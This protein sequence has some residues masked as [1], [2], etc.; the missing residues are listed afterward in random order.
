MS[1]SINKVVDF[2]NEEIKNK[3]QIFP[4]MP[5][6]E[7]LIP[8]PFI[9]CFV[10]ASGAGKT[11]SCINLVKRYVENNAFD[12]MV[13]FSPT[14]VPDERTSLTADD[15]YLKL[16]FTELYSEY[17]DDLLE[18]FMERQ[19]DDIKEFKDFLKDKKNW[20][21]Y[22]NDP[23]NPELEEKAFEIYE[24]RGVV[25]PE[26]ET[27][28]KRYPS[29][30]IILD[31]LGDDPSIKKTGKSK[32]NNFVS[33]IRHALCSFITNYQSLYMCPPT[34]RKQ[35][36]TWIIYKSQ[37]EKYLKSIYQECCSGDM[38]FDTFKKIFDLFENR[39]DFLL[40]NMKAKDRS[41]K[42]RINFNKFLDIKDL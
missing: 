28:W 5:D 16:P 11:T 14:G 15:R 29:A 10:G 17:S 32:L 20:E 36:N 33:R 34:I 26:C 12:K 9:A 2:P 25:P 31:D 39:H 37:D 35:I 30:L 41:K 3:N 13:L 42:Y 22:M 19:K 21:K 23:S 40:I 18:D 38:R 7:N 1:I 4:Q 6:S 8:L 27:P 24:R